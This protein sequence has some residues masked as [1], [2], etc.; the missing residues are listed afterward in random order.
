MEITL[1]NGIILNAQEKYFDNLPN[2]SKLYVLSFLDKKDLL[3][4]INLASR[5][6]RDL[7]MDQ[8][9]WKIRSA[10]EFPDSYEEYNQEIREPNYFNF[11]SEMSKF[12]NSILSEQLEHSPMEFPPEGWNVFSLF[13]NAFFISDTRKW[14]N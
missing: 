6:W 1:N 9:L 12:W 11:Y 13:D 10:R 8:S 5:E 4:G 14:D 2:E 3:Q 7:T